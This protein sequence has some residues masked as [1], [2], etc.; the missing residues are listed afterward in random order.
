MR[1]I[2]VGRL[3]RAWRR[4]K[5]E[6]VK[7][8]GGT[9]YLVQGSGKGKAQQMY[10]VD[11]SAETPCYCADSE[12]RGQKVTCYHTLSAALVHQEEDVLLALADMLQKMEKTG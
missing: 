12:N 3:K 5:A 6:G 1:T 2:E 8:L 11:L 9:Q 4:V 10:Y 7:Y